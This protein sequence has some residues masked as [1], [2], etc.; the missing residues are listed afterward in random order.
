MVV[1][2]SRRKRLFHALVDGCGIGSQPRRDR[3]AGSVSLLD[4]F[5]RH[6]RFLAVVTRYFFGAL[7]RIDQRACLCGR[8]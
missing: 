6:L 4:R 7:R 5:A 2:G 8:P 3:E 1:L